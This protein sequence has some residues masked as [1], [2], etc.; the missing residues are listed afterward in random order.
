[1]SPAPTSTFAPTVTPTISSAPTVGSYVV[2]FVTDPDNVG[3][4]GY[5]ASQADCSPNVTGACLGGTCVLK[6]I[7]NLLTRFPGNNR[8]DFEKSVRRFPPVAR[9]GTLYSDL[10][11]AN[12]TFKYWW[13]ETSAAYANGTYTITTDAES[14][15]LANQND[16]YDLPNVFNFDSEAADSDN[17]FS[18]AGGVT[19]ANITI[20]LPVTILPE[21]YTVSTRTDGSNFAMSQSPEEWTLS[22]VDGGVNVEIDSRT[23]QTWW[24][25]GSCGWFEVMSPMPCAK[26]KFTSPDMKSVGEIALYG[27]LG[28]PDPTPAPTPLPSV[29]PTSLP[30]AMPTPLP[31]P[32]PSMPPTSIP[33]PLPSMPPTSLPTPT[34]TYAPT[35]PPSPAPTPT[36]TMHPTYSQPPTP[37]PSSIP[38]PLPTPS[39]TIEQCTWAPTYSVT[40]CAITG[41]LCYTTE[42]HCLADGGQDFATEGCGGLREYGGTGCG[43]CDFGEG[44][45]AP[46]PSPTYMPSPAPSIS[47]VP[48]ALP[49]PEPTSPAPTTP[50]PT[51]RPTYPVRWERNVTL[52]WPD[53]YGGDEDYP[54]TYSPLVTSS[55][56]EATLFARL[57]HQPE[58]NASFVFAVSVT[59]SSRA[60]QGRFVPAVVLWPSV[61]VFTSADWDVRQPIRVKGLDDGSGVHNT[62]CDVTLTLLG[63]ST[64]DVL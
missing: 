52:T 61:L 64:G 22:C 25:I 11:T 41:G 31:S 43:C 46:L 36:P 14:Y 50:G 57:S 6:S 27:L 51:P 60:D 47:P 19:G 62:S 8:P 13:T 37:A 2:G 44:T 48:T 21:F 28:Y 55:G 29:P 9:T 54:V 7:P 45:L 18:L 63:G 17:F 1:M 15:N 12:S 32:R 30:T 38:S 4:V 20:E 39:P 10:D 40:V 23:S 53:V 33:T 58:A 16:N 49:T 35:T 24:T 5:A 42:A 59:A 34:P 3:E 56:G 26:F